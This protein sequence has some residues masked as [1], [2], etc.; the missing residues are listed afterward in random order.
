M[1][2]KYEIPKILLVDVDKITQER[3][4]NDGFNIDIGTFGNKYHVVRGEE[5]GLNCL[6]PM[7]TEKDIVIVDMNAENIAIGYNPL[8]NNQWTNGDKSIFTSSKG[9][10]YFNPSYLS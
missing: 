8:A 6:L 1:L 7:L 5:C 4:K 2:I 3:L 10:S 9:S